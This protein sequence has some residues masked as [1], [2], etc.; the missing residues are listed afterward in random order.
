MPDTDGFETVRIEKQKAPKQNKAEIIRAWGVIIGA[1]LAFAT[2]ITVAI[3]Q[4]DSV[5][6]DDLKEV[7][8]KQT[9]SLDSIERHTNEVVI[10]KLQE[11]IV[12][13]RERIARNETEIKNLKE[14]RNR[15]RPTRPTRLQPMSLDMPDSD[16]SE[17]VTVEHMSPKKEFSIPKL[18]IEQRAH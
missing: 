16:E 2:S 3:L 9:D 15:R 11:T 18:K 6:K 17:M 7:T 4:K 13:M 10:P 5:T 14:E 12:S 8:S 1:I